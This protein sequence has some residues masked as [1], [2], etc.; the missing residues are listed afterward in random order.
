MFSGQ[1][2]PLQLM[3]PLV[4]QI[5]GYLPFA[6]AKYIPIQII[7][8]RLTPGRNHARL[9]GGLVWLVIAAF[10]LFRWIW[11]EGVKRFSAVGA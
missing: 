5:A 10:L 1:F 9:C 6:I 2:V 3:P 8:G 4:Q 11:R 7:L